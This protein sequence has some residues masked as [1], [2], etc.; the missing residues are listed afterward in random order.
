MAILSRYTDLVEPLS[1]DEAFLDVSGSTALLGPAEQIARDIKDRILSETGLMASV[2]V[3]PN[4]FLAKIASD[5]EKP[6]GFVVVPDDGVR[7][8]LNPLPISRLWGVGPK[9]AAR[10]GTLGA[11]NVSDLAAIPKGDPDRHPWCCGRAPL[12]PGASQDDRKVTP[13][14][15]PKSISSETTF[16]KDHGDVN[17][18]IDTLRSLSDQ[19]ARRL[20]RQ[21]FRAGLVTLKLRYASFTTHTKQTSVAEL[22]ETG[23]DVFRLALRMFK[24]FPLAE[25]V[26]LI[27]VGTGMLTREGENPEQLTLFSGARTGERLARTVDEIQDRSVTKRCAGDRNCPDNIRRLTL[28]IPTVQAATEADMHI[29]LSLFLIL[30]QQGAQDAAQT[31][32]FTGSED[33]NELQAVIETTSGEFIMEFYAELAPN[34][35]N[36]F[37]RLAREGFYDGTIFHTTFPHGIVQAGDPLTLE[38]ERR[39]EYGSGGFNMGLEPEFS[40]LEFTAGTVVATLLPGEPASA[41]SQFFICIGDQPQ[42]TGQFTAFGHVIEGIEVVDE[43]SMTPT[44]DKQIATERVE[45]VGITIRPIPPA[46]RDSVHHGNHRGAWRIPCRHGNCLRRHRDRAPARERT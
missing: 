29:F 32:D 12:A 34:H 25:R 43:I 39:A 38:L 37:I 1:V 35:V 31:V 42:F 19:V 21:K 2:G 3:A 45:I 14:W 11:R 8:F 13:N 22:V 26:R 4:K 7:D 41:G 18:L 15:E 27:G 33:P 24:Q 30:L 5:L 20:R 36:Q 28:S 10:L 44:D 9:T 23:D 17:L 16:D 40:E 6:D 46:T